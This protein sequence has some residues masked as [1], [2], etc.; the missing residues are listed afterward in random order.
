MRVTLLSGL[1]RSTTTRTKVVIGFLTL[2]TADAALTVYALQKNLGYE[3]NPLLSGLS[4]GQ[5]VGVKLLLGIL[6]VS[7]LSRRREAMM[8]ALCIG[9]GLVV[10]WNVWVVMA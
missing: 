6:I 5:L 2:N 9:I 10:A 7:V 4:L 3:G 1:A 8:V